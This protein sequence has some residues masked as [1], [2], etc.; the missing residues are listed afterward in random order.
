MTATHCQTHRW[1][2]APH[3]MTPASPPFSTSACR[4][5]HGTVRVAGRDRKSS[6]KAKS[7][8]PVYYSAQ[9][10]SAPS[11]AP[12]ASSLAS[13]RP[14]STGL[15]S[16]SP[17]KKRAFTS[18][19]HEFCQ[20][21]RPLLPANLRNSE[22]EKLLGLA[23]KALSGTEKRKF[24]ATLNS[25]RCSGGVGGWHEGTRVAWAHVP[26]PQLQLVA[27]PAPQLQLAAPPAPQLQLITAPQLQFTSAVM[28]P[29]PAPTA[30]PVL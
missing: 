23:W 30:A 9:T 1:A 17:A 4:K 20:D 24:K 14:A 8:G 29:P 15:A 7:A 26:A 6:A 10:A 2:E 5:E 19:Y 12:P 22:R 13:K 28:L 25:D 16:T 18:P 11:A 21:L 27:P 3:L